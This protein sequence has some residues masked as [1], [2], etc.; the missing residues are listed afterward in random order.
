MRGYRQFTWL[1]VLTIVAGLFLALTAVKAEQNAA[2]RA[3]FHDHALKEKAALELGEEVTERILMA[4][5]AGLT[6]DAFQKA[7]GPLTEL[8]AGTE[9]PHADMTHSLFHEKSQRTFYLRFVD[10]R[11]TGFGSTQG[12][13]EVDTGVILETPAFLKGESVR[14]AALFA[15]QVAWC[16]TLVAGIC[17]RRSRGRVGVL[18][19]ALA[20]VCGLCWFLAPNYSPTW[21][22]ISSNDSLAVFVLLL[23][24][25]LGFGVTRSRTSADTDAR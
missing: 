21:R 20:M 6:L 11:C 1:V 16:G 4:L 15:A 10:G 24:T 9:P 12:M 18:L 2:R 19:V 17:T 5:Q 8:H 13:G 7:F 23:M 14:T 25:S 3:R 22:G